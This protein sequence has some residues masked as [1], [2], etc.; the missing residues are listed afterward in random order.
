[1]LSSLR[2]LRGVL[3]IEHFYFYHLWKIFQFDVKIAKIRC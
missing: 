3:R 1:M 2:T